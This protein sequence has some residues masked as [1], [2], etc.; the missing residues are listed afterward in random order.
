M[1]RIFPLR[2][3]PTDDAEDALSAVLARISGTMEGAK[4]N[5]SP[6]SAALDKNSL[7]FIK[8]RFKRKSGAK[9]V[10]FFDFSKFFCQKVCVYAKKVVTL[11]AF[12][13]NSKIK[14]KNHHMNTLQELTDKIY[15]EGV[16]KGKAEAAELVAKA[17]AEAKA[18]K[19]AAKAAKKQK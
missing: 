13:R 11:H 1:R 2:V 3:H 12:L 5:A 4:P 10:H 18:A 7:R 14:L 19:A 8:I 6:L 9:L 15:A 16:E 17:K